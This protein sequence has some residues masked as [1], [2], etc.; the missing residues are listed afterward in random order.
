MQAW[1]HHSNAVVSHVLGLTS[2]LHVKRAWIKG[3]P[4]VGTTRPCFSCAHRP[5][6]SNFLTA[7]LEASKKQQ[8]GATSESITGTVCR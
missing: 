1:S 8:L 3:I 2:V 5:E 6:P 4:V 7:C